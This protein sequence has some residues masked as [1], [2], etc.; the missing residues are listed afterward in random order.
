VNP[1]AVIASSISDYG[2]VVFI[3]Q[4]GPTGATFFLYKHQ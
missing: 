4:P 1:Q 2:V 3:T